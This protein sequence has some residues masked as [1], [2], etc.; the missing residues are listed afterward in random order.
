MFLF[1]LTLTGSGVTKE[2]HG[3]MIT[4]KDNI[5]GGATIEQVSLSYPSLYTVFKENGKPFGHL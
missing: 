2:I 1:F 4:M 5:S 3:L